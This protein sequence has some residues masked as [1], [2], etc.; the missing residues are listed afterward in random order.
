M[1]LG[2]LL[3]LGFFSYYYDAI[4][5]PCQATYGDK[6][7]LD[8]DDSDDATIGIDVQRRFT[9]AIRFGF[10]ISLLNFLREIIN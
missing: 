6:K 8:L 5:R 2:L 9:M 3:T 4:E 1:Q 7:P 10:Y